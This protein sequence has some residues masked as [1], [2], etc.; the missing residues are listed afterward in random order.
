[1]TPQQIHICYGK[2]PTDVIIM[3]AT[4][5]KGPKMSVQYSFN[6]KINDFNIVVADQEELKINNEKGV[7]FLYRAYLKGLKPATVYYYK[8]ISKQNGV[9]SD[10]LQFNVPSTGFDHFQSYMVLADMGPYTH[11]LQ[12]IVHEAKNNEYTSVFH[13]GD[14]AYDL[15]TGKGSTGDK[16]LNNIQLMTAKL[17]YLVSPGDHEAK[18]DFTHYRYRFSMP[19]LSWP[20][21]T[22]ELYY[23][24]DIGP[25]HFISLNTEM[26]FHVFKKDDQLA[27]LEKDLI[28]VNKR[29]KR[30]WIIVMGHRALYSS[31]DN[32][33]DCLLETPIIKTSLEEL[34]FKYGV[35]IYFGGHYHN[36]ERS[37]PVYK[38][39]VV[40]QHYKNPKAPVYIT[41]GT[42][43]QEYL[44]EP[45]RRP[46]GQWSAK[47]ENKECFGVLEI[48]NSTHLH[49][50]VLAA[51]N[52]A[53][54]DQ[55]W[56]IQT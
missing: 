47:T 1:F 22:E 24:F 17:P 39:K 42:L 6:T 15:H 40:A 12:N 38:D 13:I 5:A 18:Y 37:W 28:A 23:S 46:G 26:L 35:D 54:I 8:I 11:N 20:M 51:A 3:W 31:C 4:V 52:N 43:G 2:I 27:W 9:S 19:T 48:F 45:I 49:W 55:I 10:L 7:K 53:K 21:K 56:V 33:K 30:P 16:F 41:I 32:R 44:P 36:Y 34:F 25:T 50:K 29:S 14:I